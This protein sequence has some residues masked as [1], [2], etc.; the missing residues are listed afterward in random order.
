VH[1]SSHKLRHKWDE[2]TDAGPL[3]E[4]RDG[5]KQD[6]ERRRPGMTPSD[7]DKRSFPALYA[8]REHPRCQAA[9]QC[10][11]PTRL[12]F[13]DAGIEPLS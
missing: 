1:C 6:Y 11:S 4:A 3:K 9:Q 12:C 8:E 5:S 7:Q 2:Q 10:H 13:F